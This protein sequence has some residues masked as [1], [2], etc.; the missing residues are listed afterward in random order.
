MIFD[1]GTVVLR[2]CY[3]YVY[4]QLKIR[5]PV[6]CTNPHSMRNDS[7]E[8]VC[9]C[10]GGLCHDFRADR[11]VRPYEF[12]QAIIMYYALNMFV[13]TIL[14]YYSIFSMQLKGIRLSNLSTDITAA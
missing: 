2:F 12:V 7:S 8:Y 3:F 6:H 11:V 1:N 4:S 10:Y 9:E 5:K 14:Y 13:L